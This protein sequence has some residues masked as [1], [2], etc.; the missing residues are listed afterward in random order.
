MDKNSIIHVISWSSIKAR[1]PVKSVAS[2]EVLAAS[3]GVDE[4]KLIAA[5]YAHLLQREV[6]VIVVVDSLDLHGTI[7]TTHLPTDSSIRSDVASLRYDFDTH[8]IRRMIW[9]PG[10][11]NFA[12]PLTKVNS[13]LIDTLQVMLYTGM[14]PSTLSNCREAV[15][16][17]PTG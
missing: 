4:A 17:R 3:A 16:G 1:R 15:A 11:M 12:Y 10:N 8:A 2:A 14:I 5:A 7:T 13:P 6:D 9:I